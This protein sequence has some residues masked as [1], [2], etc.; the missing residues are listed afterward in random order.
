[1][2]LTLWKRFLDGTPEYLARHY[3]WAY[4]WRPAIW[5][6]D[7]Q[8]I[9]NLILFGQY[10]RLMKWT[11]RC[12]ERL[13]D[14][15][16]L[17]LTCVYGK[18]TPTLLAHLGERRLCLIDVATAQLEASRKKLDTER[19]SRLDVARMNAE[20]LGFGDSVFS[21]VL[22]FFLMHEMPPEARQRTLAETM[23]I[24]KPGGKLVITEYGAEPRKHWI[25]RWRWLR[26]QLL[27]WE[28]FLHGFWREDLSALL[29]REAA[30][31]GKTLHETENHAVYGG[32]YRVMVYQM[33]GHAEPK[34]R[35]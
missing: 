31:L 10:Q 4:L 32:F 11:L 33:E 35:I 16:V 28:P 23:R 6:F 7:H 8:P 19:R 15:R 1:M 27:F 20:K 30:R 3:W 22:I 2:R 13:P 29:K 24:L 17:Q 9:I 21:T 26:R 5:F 18:L 34:S 12:M 14:G 25:Y